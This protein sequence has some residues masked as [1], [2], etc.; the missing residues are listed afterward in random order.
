[1]NNKA[2]TIDEFIAAYPPEVQAIMQKIRAVIRQAAPDAQEKISYGIPTFA[3]HGNLIH[4]S[5]YEHHIGL[6]PGAGAV[7]HFLP[8]IK[9]YKTAKGTIQF[10]LDQPIPYDLIGEITRWCVEQR[11]R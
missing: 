8:Q 2:T 6:Y 3:F 7:A 5:V 4:F 10:P 11:L 9:A 1:M